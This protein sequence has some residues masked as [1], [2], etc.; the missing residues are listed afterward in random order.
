MGL[1]LSAFRGNPGAL[2][3]QYETYLKEAGFI[4]ICSFGY[5]KP[6]AEDSLS[7]VI[8]MKRIGDT[9]VIAA[10]S[11]GQGYGNEWASNF[12]VGSGERHEGFSQ[13]AGLFEDHL[14]GYLKDNGI[15]GK[16]KLWVSGFSR[17]SAVGNIL[18]ADMIE[19]GEYDDVYAYLFGV[20]RTTRQPVKY[21]GIYNICGQYDPVPSVPLQSWGYERYGTD[22]YT[23]AWESD[24][25]GVDS[26]MLWLP[27]TFGY[28][29]VLPQIL[30]GTNVKYLVT[31]KIFWS[32]NE[33]ERFPYHYFTWKGIDGSEVISFLPTSYTYQSDPKTM[34]EVWKNRSQIQD[35][36]AFLIPFGYG[37]GG[38]GPSRDYIEFLD[39]QKDLEGAPKAR[40]ASPVEFFHEM[41]EEG[42]P[43]NTYCGELYFSAHRGTYTTQA[44]V[45]ENN[46]KAELALRE[47]EFWGSLGSIFG[48]RLYDRDKAESLWKELL[49]HQFHDILPGSSIGRV[50]EEAE[51]RVG[52][53]IRAAS[54][55]SM[56][57][58]EFLTE[59]EENAVSIFNSL[60]FNRQALVELPAVFEKGAVDGE[61]KPVFVQKTG[62][63]L[64]ALV[65]LPACGA[66]VLRAAEGSKAEL[67]FSA[68]NVCETVAG[69]TM[70]NSRIRA[71]VNRCGQ[72]LSYII[73][74]SGREMTASP[75]NTFHLYQDI[76]RFYDAWDIDSNYREMEVEGL[77]EPKVTI[78]SEGIS[79]ALLLTGR[80]GNSALCQKICLDA[81]STCL[82]FETEIDWKEQHRLLKTGFPVNVYAEEGINEIQFGYIKRP[83]H[84]SRVYDKERFEVSVICWKIFRRRF[85]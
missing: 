78:L 69:F 17:A 67:P 73:K 19:S 33:G 74:E 71:T 52:A 37:D 36:D 4:N 14:A 54:E 62:E 8:G 42:G 84:R 85:L 56:A 82:R 22:L 47:M 18:A 7:D 66:V 31:Q 3:L 76:P 20:P 60:S 16:K 30:K 11:C 57:A 25:L 59:P 46:R 1:T 12:K 43:V 35:L 15:E 64:M 23:P 32:Y 9:T 65:T 27:D 24:T 80:I 81:D 51:K 13:A 55:E 21:K 45:K 28:S 72:I 39:R 44:K 68:V 10:A 50:Y 70:E 29:G 26:E 49:L 48:G 6:P 34:N 63:K 38:G 61:G 58:M 77:V 40:F 2:S 75:M 53:V 79:G 41:D 83:T 5:D